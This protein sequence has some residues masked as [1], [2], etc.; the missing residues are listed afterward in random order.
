[1]NE[2]E[3]E[4]RAQMARSTDV[5]A[6]LPPGLSTDAW[7]RARRRTRRDRVL[8]VASLVLVLGAATG[9]V[10]TR[11][12][13]PPPAQV[14][15]P[16]PSASTP[17]S[18]QVADWSWLPSGTRNG[19]PVD[20]S[21]IHGRVTALRWD[22]GSG[23]SGGIDTLRLLA[24]YTSAHPDTHVLLFVIADTPEGRAAIKEANLRDVAVFTGI[25]RGPVKDIPNYVDVGQFPNAV[26][27]DDNGT[28]TRLYIG[29]PE[30]SNLL[31]GPTVA[32]SSAY[33][34]CETQPT[35]AYRL[36]VDTVHPLTTGS[37]ADV[38]LAAGQTLTIAFD[39][40][41]ASGGLLFRQDPGDP[42]RLTPAGSQA[43][44]IITYTPD[45]LGDTT[46][47]LAWTQCSGWTSCPAP[48]TLAR[49]N[50]HV[51]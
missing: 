12:S 49:L 7:R 19:E 46:L 6:A 41:C 44:A 38:T 36:G 22:P 4:L 26:T 34:I 1:M 16:T 10:A 50:L 23:A 14:S 20:P 31:R 8:V 45:A 37:S 28:I 33:T 40:P 9:L 42:H 32:P 25:I 27:T 51:T 43:G 48:T 24:T 5:P 39:G 2:L 3:T 15:T 13:A 30:I 29:H 17:G 18:G 11:I 47:A 35:V 21:T